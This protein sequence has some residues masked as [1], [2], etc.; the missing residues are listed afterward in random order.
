MTWI[1]RRTR[2][3]VVDYYRGEAANGVVL[4]GKRDLVQ[5]FTDNVSSK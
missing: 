3:G 4:W 5:V 2:T 1:V